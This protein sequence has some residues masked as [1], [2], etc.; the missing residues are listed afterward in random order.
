MKRIIAFLL[1]F[2]VIFIFTGC[3]DNDNK[4]ETENNE[5]NK[6]ELPELTGE[7]ETWEFYNS[8]AEYFVLSM[9]NGD[10]DAAFEMFSEE[11]KEGFPVISLKNNLWNA[12]ISEYGKFIEIYKIDNMEYEEYYLCFVTLK[13]E[14]TGVT[15]QLTFSEN[16]L[17]SGLFIKDV[18]VIDDGDG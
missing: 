3:N 14:Q 11:M 9:A 6:F 13:H 4:S 1:I 16:G 17:I 5:E 2:A 12:L 18:S 10:F 8:R 15:L 7:P